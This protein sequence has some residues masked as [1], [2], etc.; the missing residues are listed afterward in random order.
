MT[1]EELWEMLYQSYR[2]DVLGVCLGILGHEEDAADAAEEAFL[3][4]FKHVD[5]LNLEGNIRGWLLRIA[6][7]TAIDMLR[8]QRRW[9]RLLPKLRW[10]SCPR[11]GDP[12][13]EC[14]DELIRE[15]LARL[16]ER[17]RLPLVLHSYGGLSYRE[18]A[19]ILHLSPKTVDVH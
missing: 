5:K 11:H 12:E 3:K 17:Y 6:A 2:R 1:K 19:E 18:I 9:Q 13:R 7:R 10:T 16:D 15:V 14:R 8:R 4:A